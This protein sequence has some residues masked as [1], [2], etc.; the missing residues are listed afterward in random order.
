M[1]RITKNIYNDASMTRNNQEESDVNSLVFEE[2]SFN[3]VDSFTRHKLVG[4]LQI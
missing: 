1:F 2:N 3:M 4:N